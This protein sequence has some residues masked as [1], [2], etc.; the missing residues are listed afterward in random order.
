MLIASHLLLLIRP[1][2]PDP[3]LK[4][5]ILGSYPTLSTHANRIYD[6]AFDAESPK[7]ELASTTFSFR[8]LLP[9]LPTTTRH[10]LKKAEDVHFQRMRWAF[11]SLAAGTF[12]A[13][14]AV[15]TKDLEIKVV[16]LD[17]GAGDSGDQEEE[18]VKSE[19][20]EGEEETGTAQ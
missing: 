12:A 15:V 7:I 19:H 8:A 6:L 2:Y 11:F 14:L 20:K 10:V 3:L 4:T 1:P 9:S 17:E 5:L 16:R 18:E 13:Y